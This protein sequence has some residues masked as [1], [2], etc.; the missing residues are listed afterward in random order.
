MG[1]IGGIGDGLLFVT[2]TLDRSGPIVL[3]PGN[4]S[5]VVLVS[6]SERDVSLELPPAAAATGRFVRVRRLDSD[7]RAFVVPRA[8][9]ELLGGTDR[10]LTLT[11]RFEAATLVSDGTRWIVYDAR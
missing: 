10:R 6:T 1:P 7:R 8:G 11:N 4:A 9:E 2:Q 5:I 3:P